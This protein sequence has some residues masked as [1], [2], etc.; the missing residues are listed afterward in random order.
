MISFE[1]VLNAHYKKVKVESMRSLGGDNR[2][3][4]VTPLVKFGGYPISL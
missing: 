3:D 2:G 4:E 1:R